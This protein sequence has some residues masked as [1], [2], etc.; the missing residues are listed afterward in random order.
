MRPQ[1]HFTAPQNWMNDPNGLI[2]YQGQYHLFYQC[3]PYSTQWGRM[4]WGHAVSKDLVNWEEKGIALFP[5]K[6]DDRS[7]CFS[8][9]AIEYKDKMYKFAM[10]G[11]TGKSV[12]NYPAAWSKIVAYFSCWYGILTVAALIIWNIFMN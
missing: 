10:N 6:T 12:G 2:Y 5:S 9:S 7:G 8:G 3:F 11:Q 1:L 4:H